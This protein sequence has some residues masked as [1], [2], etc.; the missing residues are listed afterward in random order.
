M[1]LGFFEFLR[2]QGASV[3]IANMLNSRCR[4]GR[5][6]PMESTDEQP[7]KPIVDIASWNAAINYLA[8][9]F[10]DGEDGKMDRVEIARVIRGQALET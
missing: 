6:E 1:I 4:R 9:M 5:I 2:Q 8:E 3:E 10:E 7:L